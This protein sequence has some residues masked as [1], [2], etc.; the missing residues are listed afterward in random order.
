MKCDPKRISQSY[1][2][3]YAPGLC[4]ESF[5]PR[6]YALLRQFVP[7]EFI[8]CGTLDQ[9]AKT[10]SIGFD[11]EHE[12][13]G[14]AMEAFG[15]LMGDFPLYNW[16]PATN[17]GRPFCRSHFYTRRQFRNLSIY[18]E[19]Y[20]P[21]GIDNHCAV[22]VPTRTDEV[23]FFGIERIGEVDFSKAELALLESAQVHLSNAYTLARLLDESAEGRVDLTLLT[24]AGL[25]PR[26]ADT[27]YWMNQG[28]SNSE[29]A[30]LLNTSVYTVKDH[31]TSIFNKSG[32]GN[33]LAAVLWA[34]WICRQL[35]FDRPPLF[36]NVT[37]PVQVR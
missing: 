14:P 24:K 1:Q 5:L 6:A 31:V 37:V 18:R 21:L 17:S 36:G 16:D 28:K 27:L 26:E 29:I 3:L 7:A 15:R 30:L 22:Y 20:L 13:L 12:G 4:M 9:R 32:A 23:T 10:L 33:R 2:A 25:T 11:I 35:A 34:R 8:A 19:V